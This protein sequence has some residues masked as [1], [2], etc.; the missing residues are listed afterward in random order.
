MKDGTVYYGLFGMGGSS[1][2]EESDRYVLSYALER[3]LDVEQVDSLLFT[4]EIIPG[5]STS[6]QNESEDE[7]PLEDRFY[8]VPLE[9]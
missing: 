6:A 5:E 9:S 8:V 2:T 7:L 4:K 3:I 1:L